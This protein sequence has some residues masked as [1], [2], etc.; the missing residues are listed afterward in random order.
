MKLLSENSNRLLSVSI[1]MNTI[2]TK[3]SRLSCITLKNNSIQTLNK[4]LT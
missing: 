3:N 2:L 4:A 1:S